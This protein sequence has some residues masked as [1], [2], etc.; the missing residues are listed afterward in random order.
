MKKELSEE[1]K[2]MQ[3]QKRKDLFT[4]LAIL[5]SFFVFAILIAWLKGGERIIKEITGNSTAE[6]REIY[7]GAKNAILGIGV[8]CLIVLL[9][10]VVY[11]IRD[12]KKR[13]H[14][15]NEKKSFIDYDRLE[16]ARV[17]V[18]QA[19]MEAKKQGKKT[20]SVN[21]ERYKNLK[22]IDEKIYNKKNT[23]PGMTEEEYRKMRKE[24]Y[25]RYMSLD[26]SE[27]M[28]DDNPFYTAYNDEEMDEYEDYTIFDRIK[29]F[30]RE[31]GVVIVIIAG[32][33][34]LA[35]VAAI[36]IGILL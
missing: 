5:S 27:D 12:K 20:S 3:R 35:I 7:K 15:K 22:D 10:Y 33:S 23:P 1:E 24:E 32:V 21:V 4:V 11:N 17:R 19:R 13:K 9:S 14:K 8:L 25:D 30:V 6:A 16:M 18:E 29:E 28:N 36:I 31:H 34:V 26:F 2:E